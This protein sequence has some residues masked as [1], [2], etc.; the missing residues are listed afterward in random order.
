MNK[1]C[2]GC[3]SILQS[4]N[5]ELPG[6]IPIEKIDNSNYCQRCFRLTH[7]G[8]TSGSEQEKSTNSILNN[9]NKDNI[10]KIYIIDL[11]NINDNTID[12]FKKIKGNKLLLIS[13]VDLIGNSINL[14]R[15]ID[16]IKKS[17][18][19]E[20]DIRII[21]VKDNFGVKSFLK[22]LENNIHKCYLLGPTNSGKSSLINKLLEITNSNK[23]RLTISNKRNTTLEFIRIKISD[24]LTIIDSPGFL[25]SDYKLNSKYNNIIKPKTFNMKE[26]EALLINDFYIKFK[27]NTSVTIYNYDELK[28]TKYYKDLKYDYNL[29]VEDNTDLCIN[30]LG[31]IRIKNNNE[32]SISKLDKRL[33]SIR[34]SIIR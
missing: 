10:F 25:L 32:L 14:E 18:N 31:F 33:V 29:N 30:G 2:F 8:D 23:D 5:K 1:V 26:N 3:G 16:N 9:I 21:S 7:Y 15:I 27:N 20:N 4:S 13:K 17:Y 22:Y 34:N 19:I 24:N 28:I 6:F 12:I 11:L